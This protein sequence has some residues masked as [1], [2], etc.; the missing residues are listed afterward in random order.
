MLRK[1][2]NYLLGASLMATCIMFMMF[3]IW[4]SAQSD[5]VFTKYSERETQQIYFDRGE[6]DMLNN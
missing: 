6:F 5:K 4:C 1:L 3:I 2:G